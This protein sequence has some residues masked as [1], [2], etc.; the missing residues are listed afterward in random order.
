VI[1]LSRRLIQL[2]KGCTEVLLVSQICEGYKLRKY[3]NFSFFLFYGSNEIPL[4]ELKWKKGLPWGVW[5]E[6]FISQ[7]ATPY[8]TSS[9]ERRKNGVTRNNVRIKN[10]RPQ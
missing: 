4:T 2:F 6:I 7:V 8:L 3:S 1:H 5:G 9:T 10:N